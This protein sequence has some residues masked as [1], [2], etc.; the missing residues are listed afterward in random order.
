VEAAEQAWRP[1]GELLVKKGLVTEDEL[2]HALKEQDETGQLLGTIL[3]DRGFV[4]GPASRSRP[5]AVSAR[6]SGPRSTGGTARGAGCRPRRT[7]SNWSL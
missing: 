2:K 5:S 7:S 1:L 4:S 6:G 3:V